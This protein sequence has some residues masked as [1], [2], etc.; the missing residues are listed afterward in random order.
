[1]PA[2]PFS[3]RWRGLFVP[4]LA[5][6]LAAAL[7]PVRSVSAQALDDRLL[8]F[9]LNS[10]IDW[11]SNVFR[12]PGNAADPQL[13]Q[14]LLGKSDRFT[15][16]IFGLQL[17]KAY[18]Q[19]RFLLDLSETLVRY[20]KFTLLNRDSSAYRGEWRWQLT[21]R[22][23]GVLSTDHS[24][25]PIP[26][27]DTAGN[28]QRNI[29]TSTNRN[30]TVDGWLFGGWHLIGGVSEL[31]RINSATFLG[32]PSID[33]TTTE[34]GFNYVAASQSS[35]T[36]TRRFTRGTNVGQAVDD[37][38]L[39]IDNEYRMVETELKGTWILSGK[40]TLTGRLTHIERRNPNVPQRDFSGLSRQLVY[41]WTPTGRLTLNASAIRDV[42]PFALDTSATYRID[43]TLAVEPAWQVREKVSLSMRAA[44]V[45]SD[46]LGPVVPIIGPSRSDVDRTLQ[47]AV[48]WLPYRRVTIGATLRRE[49]RASN[50][51]AFGYSDTFAGINA[52]LTF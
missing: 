18:A 31:E 9:R 12:V 3:V 34:V 13:A 24:Q 36:A 35:V 7:F 1:M 11:D 45:Q 23:S 26:F 48:K 10:E 14:G 32:L 52:A 40:S 30:F 2:P 42:L 29:A 51:A 43:T 28:L 21:P 47:F 8:T 38:V 25:A 4:L 37:T 19:Q 33:Q 20:D 44:R 22:I 15:T 5:W 27:Q 49:L 46:Y 17:N 16:T 6:A 39:F 41:A 50:I